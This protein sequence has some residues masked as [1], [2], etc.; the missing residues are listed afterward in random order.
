MFAL[1]LM[2][3]YAVTV[4]FVSATYYVRSVLDWERRSRGRPLPPGPRPLPIVGNLYNAPQHRP[5][6]GYRDLCK[7]YG[8]L[9]SLVYQYP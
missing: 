5:W 8:E 7:Q 9:S 6:I 1:E 2:E 3:I 4:L